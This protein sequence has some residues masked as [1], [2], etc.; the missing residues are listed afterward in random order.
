M[1]DAILMRQFA[2]YQMPATS[3]E[4]TAA[5]I[6]TDLEETKYDHKN[7]LGAYQYLKTELRDDQRV[8]SRLLK[9]TT[10]I[11]QRLVDWRIEPDGKMDLSSSSFE[12][13]RFVDAGQEGM[14]DMYKRLRR[15]YDGRMNWDEIDVVTASSK[16]AEIL[17]HINED[18]QRVFCTKHMIA[19]RQRQ[20]MGWQRHLRVKKELSET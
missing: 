17:Y 10:W 7:G 15:S 4:V 20:H 6:D 14:V 1:A 19:L 13:E 2:A 3:E 8:N 11:I 9:G 16:Y 18:E 5:E 12:L